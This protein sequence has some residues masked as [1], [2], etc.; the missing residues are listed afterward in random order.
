[1]T[2]KD[3]LVNLT[4][5]VDDTATVDYAI[6]L[7]R[8]FDAHLAGVAFAYDVISPAMLAGEVPPVW[9][10]E[11]YKQA[12]AAAQAAVEKFDAAVNAPG[13]RRRQAVCRET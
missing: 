12:Q 9:I 2:I 1:M 3:L 8:T 11:L 4:T 7:A 10:E 13:F 5:G 6:S